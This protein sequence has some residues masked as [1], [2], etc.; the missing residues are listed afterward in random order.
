MCT[1][2]LFIYSAHM[3]FICLYIVCLILFSSSM[4][5]F[6]LIT[7]Y[8]HLPFIHQNSAKS[9]GSIFMRK[10]KIM[11]DKLSFFLDSRVSLNHAF[12]TH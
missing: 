8:G 1:L 7:E 11:Q 3:N 10:A 2:H 5:K 12:F 4:K 6:D 9:K